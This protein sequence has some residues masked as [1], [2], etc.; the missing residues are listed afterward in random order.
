MEQETIINDTVQ[1]IILLTQ[2]TQNHH[3][4]IYRIIYG[5]L[6]NNV[7]NTRGKVRQINNSLKQHPNAYALYYY[8]NKFIRATQ[9]TTPKTVSLWIDRIDEALTQINKNRDQ[10]FTLFLMPEFYKT[11]YPVS[12]FTNFINSDALN[13]KTMTQKITTLKAVAKALNKGFPAHIIKRT[14]PIL[15]KKFSPK[16]VEHCYYYGNINNPTLKTHPQKPSDLTLF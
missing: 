14:R 13:H 1:K 7:K 3:P 6:K 5:F 12:R 16:Y 4:H 2:A 9:N 15:W 11:T 8:T 10:Y